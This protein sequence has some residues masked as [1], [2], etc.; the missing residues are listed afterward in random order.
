M[1]QTNGTDDTKR[2]IRSLR[3]LAGDVPPPRDLWPAISAEI[4]KETKRVATPI[5]A[6]AH[7]PSRMQWLAAAAVVAALAV[8][9]WVGRTLLPA[10][11]AQQVPVAANN[12]GS[13]DVANVAYV[14]DPRYLKQRAELVR[15]LETKLKTLPPETQKKV[16][17]SLA[18]IR[19]SITDIQ[20]ALGRDPANALLQE[21]LVNTY[22]DEMRVL[23]TVNEASA[24]Q[25]L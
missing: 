22:Q 15:S 18:T 5:T 20:A 25:E 8:G 17:A 2:S 24:R 16:T 3:Q 19:Q 1:T 14:R 21:M 6:R 7:Q 9:V 12:G 13:A 23:S 4:S 11:T 10:S